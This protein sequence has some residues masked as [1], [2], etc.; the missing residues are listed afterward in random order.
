MCLGAEK[1]LQYICKGGMQN[2]LVTDATVNRN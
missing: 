1:T 2:D